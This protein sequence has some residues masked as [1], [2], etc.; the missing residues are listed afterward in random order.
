MNGVMHGA[1]SEVSQQKAREESINVLAG[2]EQLCD[3]KEQDK[4]YGGDDQAGNRGHEQPFFVAGIF[5]V[6]SVDQVNEFFRPFTFREIMEREAMDQVFEQR[7]NEHTRE[8]CEKD[9]ACIETQC[10]VAIIEH[11]ADDGGI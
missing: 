6:V 4:E 8:E 11:D 5:M 1:I 2:I 9:T 7:P 3:T 10:T